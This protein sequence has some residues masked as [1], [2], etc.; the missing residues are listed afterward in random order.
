MKIFAM[1]MEC[2]KELGR[3]SF[4]PFFLPYYEDRLAEIECS[5]HHKSVLLLQSQKFEVLLESGANALTAGFTLEAVASFSSG[6]ERFYEFCIKVISA[7][8]NIS[9]V[10][11]EQMFKEMANQSERQLGAFLALH[12]IEF[13]N[14]YV[15][16]KKIIEFRNSVIHKGRI[17]TPD[18]ATSFCGRVYDEIFNLTQKLE[19]D[20]NSAISEVISHD[21]RKRAEMVPKGTPIATTTGTMFFSLA[22]K[23]KRPT[24]VEAYDEFL[25]GKNA[26]ASAVPAL[27]V[28]SSLLKSVTAPK[29]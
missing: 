25:K 24:F 7:H 18:E 29:K 10:V 17:P 12:A 9:Q 20:H 14:A 6:L 26:V 23:D 5:R 16:N 2:L 1:C 3:P 27:K 28:I 19:Q 4:E 22:R 21:L 15:P 13:G 11:Y 8:R